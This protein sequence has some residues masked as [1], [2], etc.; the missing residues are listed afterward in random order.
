M[1]SFLARLMRISSLVV[2]PGYS[3][4]RG[5][6]AYVTLVFLIV[7][8][9]AL[10]IWPPQLLVPLL[11]A[12]CVLVLWIRGLRVLSATALLFIAF[13]APFVALSVGAQLVVG[14]FSFTTTLVGVA[15]MGGLTLLGSVIFGLINVHDLT[16][17]LRRA[18]PSLAVSTALA[19]KFFYLASVNLNRLAET[20]SVNLRASG[21]TGGILRLT[22]LSKALTYVCT[23]SALESMEAL[24]TRPNVLLGGVRGEK[25]RCGEGCAHS[26]A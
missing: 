12:L 6:P 22:A 18:S 17:L 3:R 8:S 11:L 10:M 1:L 25:R 19:I 21:V 7:T 15:R 9:V 20:Y 2:A 5:V 24:Y 16:L 23:V 14:S 13:V 4:V 26:V